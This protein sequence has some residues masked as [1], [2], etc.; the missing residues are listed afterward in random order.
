MSNKNSAPFVIIKTIVKKVDAWTD[1]S[2]LG[3][4]GPGGYGAVLVFEDAAGERHE[5]RLS[6]GF[7]RTTNSRMEIMG[8][9]AALEALKEPVVIT[10]TSDSKYVVDALSKGWLNSW[11]KRGWKKADKKPVLN[12][13]L[14]ERVL[15]LKARHELHMKWV[16][17]HAG[18]PMNE[19]CD[20]LARMAAS[21]PDLPKDPGYTG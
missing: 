19:L 9:V 6:G 15:E 1:G 17:G 18:H 2:S 10:I 11:V 3:N 4:P 14:W 7:K 5:K 12:R 16:K 8:V 21:S 13:D 20:E